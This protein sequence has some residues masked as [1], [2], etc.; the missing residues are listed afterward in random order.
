M[1][2]PT[3]QDSEARGVDHGL[4]GVPERVVGHV[5]GHPMP[6]RCDSRLDGVKVGL[7]LGKPLHCRRSDIA[8]DVI[9]DLVATEEELGHPLEPVALDGHMPN[10]VRTP[11][12]PGSSSRP[13]CTVPRA[14]RD[15]CQTPFVGC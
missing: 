2:A 11:D 14:T 7:R 3:A 5:V 8:F 4:C 13:P 9:R 6:T 1:C 12:S 15:R 10:A